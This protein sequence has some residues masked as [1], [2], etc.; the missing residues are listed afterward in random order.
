MPKA[1]SF[2]AQG[3]EF[4]HEPENVFLEFSGGFWKNYAEYELFLGVCVY[5]LSKLKLFP[6]Q[7]Y[8]LKPIFEYSES[9]I[10]S[11]I[12]LFLVGV[13]FFA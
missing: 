10:L 9:A 8:L 13:G 2:Y 7:T 1:T 12:L 4:P 5:Q 6:H 11:E 3:L